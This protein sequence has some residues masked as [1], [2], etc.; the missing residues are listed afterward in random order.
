MVAADSPLLIDCPPGKHG[1]I[2]S[3]HSSLDAAIAK[4]RMT[5]LMWQAQVAEDIRAAGLGRRSFR[6][7]EEWDLDTL[8]QE[9]VRQGQGAGDLGSVVKVHI[10]RTNLTVKE[11]RN[12]DLA[13]Q[14]P[15][16]KKKEELHSIFKAALRQHGAPFLGQAKPVVA[17]LILDSAY[18]SR[19]DLILGH[20]ALGAHDPDGLSLGI[21]GSHLTYA[22]PRFFEEIPGCL[23]DMTVPGDSVGNDNGECAT[24]WEACTVGQG[25]FLHE[26]GH[27]FSRPH[28][29]GIMSRGYSRDWAQAFLA[30][31]AK[32]LKTGVEGLGPVTPDSKHGCHWDLSDL[33]CFKN[34]PHFRIP[35][36]GPV[37]PAEGPQVLF[38]DD[39]EQDVVKVAIFCEAGYARVLL[40]GKV[41]PNTSVEGPAK[42][43]HFTFDYLESNYSRGKPLILELLC[44]NG[45]EAS[46]DLWV[47]LNSRSWIKIPGSNIRLN[48]K[49][50]GDPSTNDDSQPWAVMLAKRG[51]GNTLITAN[52]IDIRVGCGLD[53]AV[54]YYRD[55]TSV[56]CGPR[57]SGYSGHN[58]GMGG[59]QARKLALPKG[60]EVTKIAVCHTGGVT[61]AGLEGLRIWLDNGKA[62][63]ALNEKGHGDRTVSYLGKFPCS[64][65]AEKRIAILT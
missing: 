37:V 20:A 58:H 43:V 65:K 57:T 2:S 14:N 24:M 54:V 19:S 38:K 18:E 34:L 40:D 60:V 32:S 39:M 22:W 15:A 36:D 28:G 16:G 6:L 56:P 48:K 64:V 31:T 63:G 62:M 47:L 10:V 26:V 29:K 11:L 4:F 8:T 27:A 3:T 25:A 52:K 61:D 5:A 7:E 1:C 50:I 23:L 49:S 12:K 17:G 42:L 21:F 41:Q 33:V 46:F 45:K 9:S 53:G 13:Q 51:P 30:R 44:M 59:H 35:T 55:G